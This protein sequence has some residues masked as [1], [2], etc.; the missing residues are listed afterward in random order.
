MLKGSFCFLSDKE[1]C[2][3]GKMWVETFI[4]QVRKIGNW[5][6]FYLKC[7]A[8]TK[9][10]GIH[11]VQMQEF[12]LQNYLYTKIKILIHNLHTVYTVQAYERD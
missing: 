5:E 2:L 3:G 9:L 7:T 4:R 8:I 1:L 6:Y 12:I 10:L 11:G